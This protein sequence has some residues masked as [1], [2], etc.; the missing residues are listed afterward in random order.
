[1]IIK[2]DSNLFDVLLWQYNDAEKLQKIISDVQ[3]FYNINVKEHYDNW[4]KDFLNVD[5]ANEFGL[6]LWARI[7]NV[8]FA[9]EPTQRKVN[10]VFAFDLSR[11]FYKS[12]FGLNGSKEKRLTLEQKRLIIKLIY[13]KRYVKPTIPQIKRFLKTVIDD[14]VTISD[15][16]DMTAGLITFS[17]DISQDLRD[18]IIKYDLLPRAAGTQFVS[19]I[20]NGTQFGLGIYNRNFYQSNFSSNK[21]EVL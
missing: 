3:D 11:N 19:R 5:T 7:L 18:V 15:N 16:F 20:F 1:M 12:N 14:N 4:F 8:N 10:N 21:Y 9:Q 2:F 17:K 13:L 6:D